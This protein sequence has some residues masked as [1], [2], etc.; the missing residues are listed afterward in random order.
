MTIRQTVSGC[1][2]PVFLQ[3][4]TGGRSCS[5]YH[6][7]WRSNVWSFWQFDLVPGQPHR[8]IGCDVHSFVEGMGYP[9]QIFFSVHGIPVLRGLE[10]NFSPIPFV[11]RLHYL[12]KYLY[13]RSVLDKTA[14]TMTFLSIEGNADGVLGN[15]HQCFSAMRMTR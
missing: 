14:S 2:L 15:F 1:L 10:A 5:R 13:C 12:S 7:S 6:N 3:R 11:S 4:G 8:Q 9:G